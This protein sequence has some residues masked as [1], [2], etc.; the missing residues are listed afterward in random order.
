MAFVTEEKRAR[1]FAGEEEEKPRLLASNGLGRER[2]GK[3]GTRQKPTGKR[4]VVT[5]QS[6][7]SALGARPSAASDAL[8]DEGGGIIARMRQVEAAES[9]NPKILELRKDKMLATS[10]LFKSLEDA[11]AIENGVFGKASATGA[12]SRSRRGSTVEDGGQNLNIKTM[13]EAKKLGTKARRKVQAHTSGAAKVRT[14]MGAVSYG[15][16][17]SSKNHGK[18]RKREKDEGGGVGHFT[19]KNQAYR[20]VGGDMRAFKKQPVSTDGEKPEDSHVYSLN[21][22]AKVPTERERMLSSDKVISPDRLA[23]PT[24]EFQTLHPKP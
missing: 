17:E 2:A 5:S 11:N 22:L 13:F 3:G 7:A 18:E 15:G 24:H 9:K 20:P 8:D 12:G 1:Q 21:P 14:K 4:M 19:P 23:P 6:V 10:G 16:F